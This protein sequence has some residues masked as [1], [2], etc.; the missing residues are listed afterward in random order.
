MKPTIV[1]V[2]RPNVGKSTLFNALTK[3]RDALVAN[4]PGLT[5]D[6][7]YGHG[8]VGDKPYLVVDTGGFQPAE[9]DG[10]VCEIDKQ[11][12]LAIEEA[13]A[14]I[15]LL[16][17]RAGLHTQDELIARILRCQTSPV[18]VVINK[19]E[20]LSR[21][22][23]KTEFYRLGLGE[24]YVISAAHNEGVGELINDILAPFTCT[25]EQVIVQRP[26]FAVIGRPNVGKSTLVNALIGE[27]RL[28]T[29]SEAG[30][31]RDAVLVD[32][33]KKGQHYRVIDTAGVRRKGR[34]KEVIEKFS[35]LKSLRAIEQCNVVVLV[36]DASE[37]IAEQD[38]T[39]AGFTDQLGKAC[40]IVLNKWD[41]LS[42]R[43][44]E[45]IKKGILR[46]L[47]FLDYAKVLEISALKG[48]GVNKLLKSVKKAYDSAFRKLSTPQLTR[49]LH[50]AI[51]KQAPPQKAGFRPKMRYAHQGG[52][53][54]PTIIIHGNSLDKVSENYTRYLSKYLSKAFDLQGTPIKINYVI[55]KNPYDDKNKGIGKQRTLR[56]EMRSKR[57]AKKEV[58][59]RLNPTRRQVSI[60]KR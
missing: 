49:L 58:G 17:A 50:M 2:G 26:C 22:L 60:K 20:G 56:H 18:H 43:E 15:F 51:E 8:Q 7:H 52:N 3:S 41:L 30:T 25:D 24:P 5:R 37:A 39:L 21:E 14:I 34:V 33:V 36:L 42:K 23:A 9:D 38:A 10:L 32:F 40:V 29:S 47:Y 48:D 53:N 59:K 35:V 27:S 6:R 45:Q 28:I 19:A 44:A 16:D 46:K 57:I 31:T 55:T 12:R 13:D 1:I 11:T 54:P 4:Q